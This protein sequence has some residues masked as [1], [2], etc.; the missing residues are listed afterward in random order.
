MLRPNELLLDERSLRAMLSTFVLQI[1]FA[2]NRGSIPV[3]EPSNQLSQN[4]DIKANVALNNIT[5]WVSNLEAAN[6]IELLRA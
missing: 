4:V 6:L 5:N 1:I 2:D 3:A